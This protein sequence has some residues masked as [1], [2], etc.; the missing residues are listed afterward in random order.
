MKKTIDS[1]DKLIY[2]R[3]FL[4]AGQ[5]IAG[6]PDW[7]RLDITPQLKLSV[8]PELEVEQHRYGADSIT[9]LGFIFDAARPDATAADILRDLWALRADPQALRRDTDRLGGRW[10]IVVQHAGRAWLFN[11]ATG[12]RHICHARIDGAVVCS[13]Q[14]GLIAE[15]HQLQIDPA[16]QDFVRARGDSDLDVYWLPGDR[17]LY[18]EVRA[19]LPN[20]VL[21]LQSG[22][23]VRDWPGAPLPVLDHA[24]VLARSQQTL[25]GFLAAAHRRGGGLSV[26]MTAGWDSRLVLAM[27]QPHA[28]DLYCYTLIYPNQ[29]RANRDVAVPAR[30]LRKLGLTHHVI[31]YPHTVDPALRAL[32]RRN[33]VS[34]N[35]A[36]CADTQILR[37]V[38]PDGMLCLTGDVAEIVKCH[39]RLGPDHS[40]PVTPADLARLLGLPQHPFA[41]EALRDWQAGAPADGPVHLLD[42]LCWEQMAGR[43]Q[44]MIRSEYD[45]VQESFAPLNCRTLLVEMLTID[46]SLRKSPTFLFFAELI[47]GLWPETLGEPINPPE[48]VGLKSRVM[49]AVGRF[50][51]QRLIPPGIKNQ[52]RRLVS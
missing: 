18:R 24:S 34:G 7:V 47:R 36:F 23:V 22:A 20:H 49:R 44:A 27:C 38:Y 16:A 29:S 11:D 43:W 14:A 19:L 52:L 9:L 3:Q 45:V 5:H 4:L 26:P 28:A 6:F 40:G 25:R 8:H 21:D 2:R 15:L 39:F 12:A 37:E 1:M 35:D 41:L 31:S 51:L 10:I 46:E 17:T 33:N 42:L 30:L 48:R 13:S 32:C 50:G